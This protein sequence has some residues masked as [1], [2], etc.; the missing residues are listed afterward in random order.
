MPSTTRP[1]IQT[2][3]DI[4]ENLGQLIISTLS[5][6]M[7]KRG[8]MTGSEAIR[9]QRQ[10]ELHN[11]LWAYDESREVTP[12]VLA[13]FEVGEAAIDL[14]SAQPGQEAQIIGNVI[15]HLAI[16]AATFSEQQAPAAPPE[17]RR[18]DPPQRMT[19]PPRGLTG[20]GLTSAP[21]PSSENAA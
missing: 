13:A 3:G 21:P 18:E 7:E 6:A 16:L 9:R 2:R 20:M 14:L 5:S 17:E 19:M 11:V 1:T 8:Q 10:A 15:S 4:T 12:L